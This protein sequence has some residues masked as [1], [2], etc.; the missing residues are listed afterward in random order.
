M[1]ENN[2]IIKILK[3]LQ[4]NLILVLIVG[5]ITSIAVI[6]DVGEIFCK[7][8]DADLCREPSEQVEPP[9]AI[10]LATKLL[11]DNNPAGLQIEILPS[12]ILKVGDAMRM[13]LRSDYDGFL[14]VFDIN[15]AGEVIT[16]F[17]NEYSDQRQQGRLKVGQ[18]LVIPDIHYGFDFEVQKPGRVF[19]WLF[20]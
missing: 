11:T 8:T 17:P 10:E 14:I 15:Q 13:R 1:Q 12:D 19:W 6:I 4:N 5:I 16:L 18:S 9:T 7:F 20:W 2:K 3:K